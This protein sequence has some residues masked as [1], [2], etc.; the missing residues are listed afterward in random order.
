MSDGLTISIVTLLA[1]CASAEKRPVWMKTVTT[2][3]ARRA[4]LSFSA[5]RVIKNET[6][7][8]SSSYSDTATGNEREVVMD[9]FAGGG[10]GRCKRWGGHQ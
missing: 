6:D 3:A 8:F 10:S 4:L 9:F 7:S 5:P 1:Y 2:E